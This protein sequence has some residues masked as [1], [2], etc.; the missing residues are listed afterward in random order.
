MK[1]NLLLGIIFIL[2][3]FML[4]YSVML[5]TNYNYREEAIDNCIELIKY[6]EDSIKELNQIIDSIMLENDYL[7]LQIEQ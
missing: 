3:I 5:K 7:K 2:F 4:A 6:R 1:K